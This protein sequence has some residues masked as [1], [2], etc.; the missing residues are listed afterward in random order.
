MSSVFCCEAI[1]PYKGLRT[2]Q[3][4]KFAHFIAWSR[5]PKSSSAAKS[6]VLQ[7]SGQ[8]TYAIQLV[9]QVNYGPLESKRYFISFSGLQD[10]YLE[11]TEEFLI[12]ANFQ[13]VNSFKNYKCDHHSKF[14]EINLYQKDPVNKHHWRA[15]LAR[16][17]TSI[18]L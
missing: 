2:D 12:Q 7:E 17:A 16:P 18:D 5:Y 6:S 4:A 14:F 11:A 9:R 15:D 13:K 3:E 10:T 1:K 8:P